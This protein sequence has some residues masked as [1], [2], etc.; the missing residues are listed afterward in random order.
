V[1]NITADHLNRYGSFEDYVHAKAHIFKN[2]RADDYLILN[3]D[4]PAVMR[5]YDSHM[6]RQYSQLK[7]VHT[8]FFSRKKMIE[9]ISCINSC[10]FLNLLSTPGTALSG[11]FQKGSV[12]PFKLLSLDEIRIKGVHN[13]ENAMAASLAALISGC[14]LDDIRSVLK[15]FPG[16]EHRLEYI[17]EING[18]KFMNDSKGTNVSAVMKSIESFDN[19]VLIMGGRDKKGDFTVLRDMVS[20]K[21]KCLVLLGEAKEKIAKAMDGVTEMIFVKD[22]QEAVETSLSVASAGDVVLLSPGCASFDIYR[23]FEQRGR[24][25]KEAVKEIRKRKHE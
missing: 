14:S 6:G 19:I 9:G 24:K 17:G 13:L 12:P 15:N 16:L 4:D 10:L 22:M 20:R 18:V 3:A 11:Y 25:F 2:Q 23:D 8:L 7:N 1:L 5:L 21:V